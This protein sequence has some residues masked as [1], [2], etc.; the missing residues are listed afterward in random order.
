MIANN[1][2]AHVPELNDFVAGLKDRISGDFVI[3]PSE[4]MIGEDSLFLDDMT[5]RDVESELD[6]KVIRSGYDPHE[7][8]EMIRTETLGD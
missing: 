7:F 1:V 3:L 6:V 5:L 2:L 8:L 4:A